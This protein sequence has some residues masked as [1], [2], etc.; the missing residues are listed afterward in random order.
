MFDPA[1][2]PAVAVG[3]S[4]GGKTTGEQGLAGARRAGR[5]LAACAA[6]TSSST[7]PC[8]CAC[9]AAPPPP[10]PSAPCPALPQA[11][12]QWP[13]RR[14]CSTPH[15]YRQRRTVGHLQVTG[16]VLNRAWFVQQCIAV[17]KELRLAGLRLSLPDLIGRP[18]PP[19]PA[20]PR[21]CHRVLIV[22][23]Q[24][25]VVHFVDVIGATAYQS[26]STAAKQV[27]LGAQWAVVGW[28]AHPSCY[29]LLNLYSTLR[30][31]HPAPR[32]S[33]EE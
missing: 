5:Q 3:R 31:L 25:T 28:G 6:C 24:G 15:A 14:A 23:K 4:N 29:H 30:D 32:A 21:H 7:Q 2:A 17:V 12:L 22:D 27:R 11:H 8:P 1:K 33:K 18:V 20:D 9:A 13:T 16:D 26:K 19:F 10:P